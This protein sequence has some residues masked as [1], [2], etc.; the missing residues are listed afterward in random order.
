MMNQTQTLT[1]QMDL[2]LALDPLDDFVRV[3]GLLRRWELEQVVTSGAEYRIEEAGELSDK[4][5]VFAVYRREHARARSDAHDGV[6]VGL[7]FDNQQVTVRARLLPINGGEPLMAILVL[8]DNPEDA[9]TLARVRDHLARSGA[10]AALTRDG[11]DATTVA[12]EGAAP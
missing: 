8:G 5:Q 10:A 1:Q 6:P 3:P 9:A 2:E 12:P 11:R 4:T 7:T